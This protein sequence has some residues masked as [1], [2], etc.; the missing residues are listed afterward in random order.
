[1]FGRKK[2]KEL[3]NTK[4]NIMMSLLLLLCSFLIFAWGVTAI[5]AQGLLMNLL[6]FVVLGGPCGVADRSR[7]MQSM[8]VLSLLHYFSNPR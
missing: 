1:M 4:S 5:S 8:C 6:L 3:E 2:K 7:P